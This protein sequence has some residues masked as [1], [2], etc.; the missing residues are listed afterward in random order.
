MKS[1]AG[2]D[3]GSYNNN[4]VCSL[5]DKLCNITLWFRCNSVNL[6]VPYFEKL[7]FWSFFKKGLH[8]IHISLMKI[9]TKNVN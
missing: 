9:K 2:V 5:S 7:T 1:G 3:I 8:L 6:K 4:D